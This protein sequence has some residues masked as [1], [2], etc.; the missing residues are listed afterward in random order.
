MSYNDQYQVTQVD[1]WPKETGPLDTLDAIGIL[2]HT[3]ENPRWLSY[4]KT[5]TAHNGKV[6]YRCSTQRL[7]HTALRAFAALTL[8]NWAVSITTTP[9]TTEFNVRITAATN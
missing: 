4:R 2:P 3:A 7:D 1:G 8:E 5:L 9:G 6:T